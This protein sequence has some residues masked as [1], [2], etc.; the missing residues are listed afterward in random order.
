MFTVAIVVGAFCPVFR[1]ARFFFARLRFFF[2]FR[3]FAALLSDDVEEEDV[4]EEEEA[5][6]AVIAAAVRNMVF[7]SSFTFE[8]FATM[9]WSSTAL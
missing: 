9:I 6:T 5:P 4:E 3:F 7:L 1:F 2:L 8:F